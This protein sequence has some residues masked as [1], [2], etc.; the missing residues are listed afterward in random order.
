[1]KKLLGLS[2]VF[3]ITLIFIGCEI[4]SSSEPSNYTVTFNTN[5]GAAI[6]SIQYEEGEKIAK[7]IDPIKEGYTFIGWYG[8]PGLAALWNFD[9]NTINYSGGWLYRPYPYRVLDLD[10]V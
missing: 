10:R 5:G 1:M 8:D 6:Q 3:A 7:P 9:T 4:D 2:F